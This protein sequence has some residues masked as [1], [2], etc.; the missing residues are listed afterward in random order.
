MSKENQTQ[1]IEEKTLEVAEKLETIE[2]VEE[3]PTKTTQVG[4]NLNLQTK[5]EI[6]SFL[7]SNLDVFAWSHEDMPGISANI[8]QHYL[9]VDFEKK[10]VQQRRRFFAFERNKVV[11][12]EVKQAAHC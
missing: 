4:M 3:D 7:R 8:I 6:I 2:L 11:M 10:P 12:E 5:E 1:I 9:N